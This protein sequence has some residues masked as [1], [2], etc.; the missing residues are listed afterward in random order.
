MRLRTTARRSTLRETA[1]P[2]ARGR[3]R[4]P[5]QGEHGHATRR[6]RRCRRAPD[7]AVGG[8][9]LGS[10]EAGQD[11]VQARV[12]R[13]SGRQA[14]RP[15]RGG[16]RSC[17]R[18][19]CHAHGSRSR[20]RLRLLGWVRWWPWRDAGVRRAERTGDSSDGP[21]SGSST[22]A[23]ADARP[24]AVVGWPAPAILTTGRPERAGR[25]RFVTTLWMPGPAAQNARS[26]TVRRGRSYLACRCR[27][28]GRTA[29]RCC[30]RPTPSSATSRE[31]LP[32]AD[33]RAPR[34]SAAATR[35]RWCSL[36][37][38]A[39]PATVAAPGAARAAD[40]GLRR[41]PDPH[42]T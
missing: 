12:R 7:R 30:T 16:G 19:R 6:P 41:P 42:Y 40:G 18:R 37:R 28:A 3:S 22:G 29:G 10:C 36:P 1:S 2:A 11:P 26:R 17:G 32:A 33:P 27:R 15:W 38:V 13:G 8:S 14:L 31:P 34:T 4:A 21:R 9:A 23:L 24:G 25:P 39:V 20:L 5:V 35:W